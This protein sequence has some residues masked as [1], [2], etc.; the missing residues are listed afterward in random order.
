MDSAIAALLGALIGAAGS[1][2]A[3]FVQHKYQH[4]R[5]L[6]KIAADLARE[7][8]KNRYELLSTGGKISPVSAFVSYHFE[9]LLAMESG[10]FDEE[11]VKELSQG[12]TP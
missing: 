2:F 11:K 1:A 9:V 12:R 5:D 4:R 10:E 7:D 8:W 3:I 6:L